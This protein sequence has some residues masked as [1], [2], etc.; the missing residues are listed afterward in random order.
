MS[1]EIDIEEHDIMNN[2]S[3]KS[4]FPD[5]SVVKKEINEFYQSGMLILV[6]IFF[7]YS[8]ILSLEIVMR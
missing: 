7:Y 3:I 8:M 1:D 2:P 6:Y 5:L 4:I